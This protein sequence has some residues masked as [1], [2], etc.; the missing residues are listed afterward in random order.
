MDF[1]P[2]YTLDLSGYSNLGSDYQKDSGFILGGQRA[3]L[4]EDDSYQLLS[5]PSFM[6]SRLNLGSLLGVGGG[7]REKRN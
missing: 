1:P 7:Y 3:F 4:G 6:P 2:D 5:L